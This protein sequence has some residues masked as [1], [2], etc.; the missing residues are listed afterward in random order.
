MRGC[1]RPPPARSRLHRRLAAIHEFAA[2]KCSDSHAEQQRRARPGLLLHWNADSSVA[3]RP[4]RSRS[5]SHGAE[6]TSGG[7]GSRGSAHRP[8][9]FDLTFLHPGALRPRCVAGHADE[10]GLASRVRAVGQVARAHLVVPRAGTDVVSGASGARGV[11]PRNVARPGALGEGSRVVL[12]RPSAMSRAVGRTLR[13]V[14][15][16]LAGAGLPR[17]CERA[18]QHRGGNEVE[19]LAVVPQAAGNLPVV[20]EP[21]SRSERVGVDVPSP[22]RSAGGWRGSPRAV[23]GRRWF[24]QASISARTRVGAR[25]TGGSWTL[26]S[27]ASTARSSLVRYRSRASAGRLPETGRGT[28][29]PAQRAISAGIASW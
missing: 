2:L 20:E 28:G 26:A 27:S 17:A 23:A 3:R 24:A 7:A 19:R 29:P 14:D 11:R 10:S 25:C 8:L 12:R 21:W 13:G 1:G 5:S 4:R 18:V 22:S 15:E 6:E 16:R 9:S